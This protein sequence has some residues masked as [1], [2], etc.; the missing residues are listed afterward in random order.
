MT[1]KATIIL[2]DAATGAEISRVEEHNLVTNALR[3]IFNPPHF[4]L[5]NGFDYSNLFRYGLPMWKYFLGGVM[6]LGSREEEDAD[7]ILLS[8]NA[9]PIATA[10]TEY[11]GTC[12][13]RGTLNRNETYQTENGYHFTWDFATDKANGTINCICLTN[14]LFGDSGF[15]SENFGQGAMF[16]SPDRAD[17]TNGTSSMKFE[18]GYGQYVGTYEDGLHVFMYLTGDN[19]LEFRRYKGVRPDALQI[20]DT[21]GLSAMSKPVSVTTLPLGA[22]VISEEYFFLDPRLKTVYYFGDDAVATDESSTTVRYSAVNFAANTGETHTVKLETT[23]RY[24]NRGAVFDGRIYLLTGNGVEVFSSDGSFI[25]RFTD[26]STTMNSIFYVHNDQLMMNCYRDTMCFAWDKK[27]STGHTLYPV[28]CV[29]TVPAPYLPF[30]DRSSHSKGYNSN[31][32]KPT[33]VI[34][35]GYKATINNLATPIVKTSDNTLKI[36]YDITN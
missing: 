26:L 23:S 9:V 5:L 10:G 6:L 3:N 30:S 22:M 35:A 34:S 27:I 32:N 36:V 14:K 8:A 18:Y 13:T 16:I 31:G 11:A 28:G 15:S 4:A 17:I 24:Y 7:N 2:S 20:N 1:G 25:R 12:T 29:S 19:T 21:Y 33:L